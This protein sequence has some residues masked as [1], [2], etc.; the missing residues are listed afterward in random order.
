M[1]KW[2]ELMPDKTVT[3]GHSQEVTEL[4]HWLSIYGHHLQ[5]CNSFH[6]W[7]KRSECDCGLFELVSPELHFKNQEKYNNSY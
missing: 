4:Q 1:T 2:S 7:G 5:G 3:H 6:G